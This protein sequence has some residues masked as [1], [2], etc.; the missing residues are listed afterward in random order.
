MA[1]VPC[2]KCNEP[3]RGN[4]THAGKTVSCPHCREKFQMP[5]TIRSSYKLRR[6]EHKIGPFT[7]ETLKQMAAAGMLLPT[8]TLREEGTKDYVPVTTIEGLLPERAAAPPVPEPVVE[9]PPEP[10]GPPGSVRVT[11]TCTA[12]FGGGVYQYVPDPSA[13]VVLIPHAVKD[14]LPGGG[15]HPLMPRGLFEQ[16]R[17]ELQEKGAHVT[18]TDATGKA[19]LPAVPP[20]DYT[21]LI[22]S[23][24]ARNGTDPQKWE[25]TT[26]QLDRYFDRMHAFAWQEQGAIEAAPTTPLGEHQI[27]VSEVHVRSGQRVEHRHTF[28]MAG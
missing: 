21:L 1:V 12:I 24:S 11:S 2:P 15:L 23:N 5:Q 13:L 20:G 3:V 7:L 28:P 26:A 19:N 25:R 8:D 17:R 6:N 18:L 9:K 10:T 4:S 14:K 16:A 22:L 27:D